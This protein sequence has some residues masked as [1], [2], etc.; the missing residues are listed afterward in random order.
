MSD[1]VP[2]RIRAS[3]QGEALSFSPW[4]LPEVGS[5]HVVGLE[6]LE[7]VE[8]QADVTVL[9]DEVDTVAHMTLADIEAIREQAYEEGFAKGKEDGYAFGESEGQARGEQMG[10]E[11]SQAAID[12]Q[13]E[14]LRAAIDS[15]QKPIAQQQDMLCKQLVEMTEHVAAAVIDF[16]VK[17]NPDIVLKAFNRAIELLPRQ[18]ESVLINVNPLDKEH[19]QSI[20]PKR[21]AEAWEVV[22]DDEVSRGGCSIKTGASQIEFQLD[23]RFR[24]VVDELYVRLND[25]KIDA[26]AHNQ[27]TE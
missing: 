12:Q 4:I 17:A 19:L 8:D 9:E 3:E 22:A 13:L 5:S 14:L 1:K 7:V 16:E 23:S 25:E 21:H 11:R 26:M 10:L 27:S 15:L 20:I 24:D 18:S 6:T 2:I